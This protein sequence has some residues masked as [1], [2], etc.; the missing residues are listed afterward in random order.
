MFKTW[1]PLEK[2]LVRSGL[3]SSLLIHRFLTVCLVNKK[4]SRSRSNGLRLNQCLFK[5]VVLPGLVCQDNP[6]MN[7]FLE[8]KDESIS[9]VIACRR[10]GD[11]RSGTSEWSG[12]LENC[13]QRVTSGFTNPLGSLPSSTTGVTTHQPTTE[14]P[15]KSNPLIITARVMMKTEDITETE[16]IHQ[17]S[18]YFKSREAAFF[19][20]LSLARTMKFSIFLVVRTHLK[21]ITKQSC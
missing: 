6:P 5:K 2:L 14:L 4:I 13:Q 19:I 16:K 11:R 8:K 9:V 7:I 17:L 15:N 18:D 10:M 21:S 1:S 3:C 20:S 12:E